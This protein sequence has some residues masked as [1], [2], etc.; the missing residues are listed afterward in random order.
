MD[1]MLKDLAGYI[2]IPS[3]LTEGNDTHPYGQAINQALDHLLMLGHRLGFHTRNLDHQVGLIE[4][5]QGQESIGILVHCDVV[6]PGQGWETD[7]FTLTC[8]DGKLF[9]RGTID[10]KGPTIACL[11]AMNNLKKRNVQLKRK[12][13]MIIGTDE[14]TLWRGIKR[15]T[16]H[17]PLPTLGFSPDGDFPLIHGEKGI[18][19]IDLSAEIAS[20]HLSPQVQLL[21]INGGLSRNSVSDQCIFILSCS[22]EE[23]QDI[24]DL[25]KKYAKKHDLE[26]SLHYENTQLE[27]VLLGQSAHAMSPEKGV[28]AITHSL[29][30]LHQIGHHPT[31]LLEDYMHLIGTDTWG[32]QLGCALSDDVS[33][34]LTLNVGEIS[35]E[36]ND[37]LLKIN[38]RYPVTAS[39]KEILDKLAHALSSSD[40]SLQVIDDLEPLYIPK[41][42]PIVSTLMGVYQRHTDDIASKPLVIG[43]GTYARVLRNTVAF[44]PL[45]PTQEDVFHQA[46]EY[47]EESHFYKLVS[48]YEEA[49]EKL[50]NLRL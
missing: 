31:P 18:L 37:L 27:C 28:N 16:E 6:A 46:N 34:K 40:F 44:G 4:Y 17:E 22:R 36:G 23:S 48:I 12:V 7:P 8:K 43:G 42:S 32:Q 20:I 13:Q 15:F 24:S 49:I 14:E 5:G 26:C 45:L 3:V 41:S 19:D 10:N 35:Y 39:S 50:A 29:S 2:A 47:I 21:S 38:I 9:G 30:F 1:S 25:C 33:G 11:Y